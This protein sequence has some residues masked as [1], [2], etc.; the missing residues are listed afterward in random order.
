[1]QFFK[2]RGVAITICILMIVLAL[3]IGF[4]GGKTVEIE[5]E[6]ASSAA[7][8]AKEHADEYEDFIYDKA[9]LLSSSAEEKLARADAALDYRYSSIVA[10]GIVDG[11]DGADIEDAAYDLGYEIGCGET[12]LMLLLDTSTQQWQVVPGTEIESYV[13]HELRLLFTSYLGDEVFTGSADRQLP[14]LFDALTDWYEENI[15]VQTKTV[16]TN[17]SSLASVLLV[18]CF[19]IFLV[20]VIVALCARPRRS[21]YGAPP[22]S[23]GF[24]RGMFFG[25]MMNRHHHRHHHAPPPPRPPQHHNPP[26]GGLGGNPGG[27]GGSH[28]GSFGSSNRGGSFGGSSRSGGFGSSG[29]G[30]SF[31]GGSRGG[32]GG[33][34]GGRGRR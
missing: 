8:W 30:G 6:S 28:S 26:H 22:R 7:A 4:S 1:M 25:S 27:F 19:V 34:F 15:P 13:D 29:R 32:G 16:T 21:Y 2:K 10:V 3:I 17:G 9:G 18:L 31:G 24:W 12:D 33:S 14:A 5:P 20:A 11:L 23:G